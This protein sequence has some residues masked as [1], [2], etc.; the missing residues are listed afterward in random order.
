MTT[1]RPFIIV[2]GAGR[3]GTSAV[4]RV[5]HESGVRMGND[6]DAPS[7]FNPE[8]YY[9][10][11]AVWTLNQRLLT[12]LGMGDLRQP[13]R[14][15]SRS[16]VLAAATH[17]EPA[18]REL[19]ANAAAG[20]KDPRF[21]ITLEAWLPCL[22]ARPKLVV[23]LRS[24]DAHAESVVR[25]YGLVDRAAAKRLWAK[26]YRR[27]LEVIQDYRLEATCVEF[28]ALVER[29]KQATAAL[30]EFVG[31]SLRPDYVNPSLQRFRR[32]VPTKYARLYR[33]VLALANG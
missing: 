11:T 21:A 13:E 23:C 29:P 26:N 30:S 33:E 31:H 9:E 6:F 7:E 15:P 22:P 2:T 25:S 3:S 24:P 17:H 28:D 8:G 5:L 20:W 12:D 16:A 18:M 4:A 14:W 27:L 1:E 10:E 32:P 19:V